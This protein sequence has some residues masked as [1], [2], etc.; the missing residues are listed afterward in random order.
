[1]GNSC[2]SDG[3]YRSIQPNKIDPKMK[4]KINMEMS[5][6]HH[7]NGNFDRSESS[8]LSKESTPRSLGSTQSAA[9]LH[10]LMPGTVR[11]Y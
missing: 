8:K 4:A 6:L 5:N 2:P 10:K 3:Q 11:S 1:M 9:N 7:G